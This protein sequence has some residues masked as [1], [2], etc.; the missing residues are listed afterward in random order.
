[1]DAETL[2]AELDESGEVMVMVEEF[3]SPLELHIHDTTI[4]D[5]EITLQLADGTLTVGIDHVTGYWTHL[6]SLDDYDLH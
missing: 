2:Q 3:D 5:G 4:E 1:M 6:H